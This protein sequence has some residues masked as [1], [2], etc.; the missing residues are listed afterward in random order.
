VAQVGAKTLETRLFG[1]TPCGTTD[2]ITTSHENWL[3]AA[4]HGRCLRCRGPLWIEQDAA[5][6]ERES[7]ERVE[8]D[9]SGNLR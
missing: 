7:K 2:R 9:A 8:R 6:A 1:C 3:H 5:K 4:I